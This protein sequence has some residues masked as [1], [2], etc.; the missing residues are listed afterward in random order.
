MKGN[1]PEPQPTGIG[2]EAGGDEAEMAK[3]AA[4]FSVGLEEALTQTA[5]QDKALSNPRSLGVGRRKWAENTRKVVFWGW[6]LST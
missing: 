1:C 4:V 3:D 2:G 6:M 5:H